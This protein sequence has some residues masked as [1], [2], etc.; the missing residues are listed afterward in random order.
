MVRAKEFSTAHPCK[1]SFKVIWVR[2]PLLWIN[3]CDELTKAL[4]TALI[5]KNWIELY[6]VWNRHQQIKPMHRKSSA[7]YFTYVQ[8]ST[9]FIL[10]LTVMPKEVKRIGF[11]SYV[12]SELRTMLPNY[13][14]SGGRYKLYLISYQRCPTRLRFGSRIVWYLY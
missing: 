10:H 11:P 7:C 5:Q 13:T 6:W 2:S 9:Q 3:L 12:S 1:S 8:F 4:N 14:K